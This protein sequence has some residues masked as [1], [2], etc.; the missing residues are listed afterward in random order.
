[1]ARL[2]PRKC[3][4]LSFGCSRSARLQPSLRQQGVGPALGGPES[5]L[6]AFAETANERV[7]HLVETQ[8]P[9]RCVL[10]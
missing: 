3:V 1:M 5:P 6:E 2:K 7:L 4:A 10:Q 8:I 9:T